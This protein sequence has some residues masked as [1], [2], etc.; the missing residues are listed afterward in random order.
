MHWLL[1]IGTEKTGSSHLQAVCS[2]ARSDLATNGIAF[3]PGWAHDERCMLAG[4]I[5][6]GNARQ[7]AIALREADD[8]LVHEELAAA[9]GY[10][11]RCNADRIV[12]T[13]EWLLA[14]LSSPGQTDRLLDAL[15][16]AGAQSVS[17]LI[18]LRDPLE[19]CLSLYKHRAKRGTAGAI[20]SWVT[21]GY[22][23]PVELNG[24]RQQV[25]ESGVELHVRCYR[26]TPGHLDQIFFK[27]WLD[28]PVPAV[29]VPKSVN[30]SLTLSE[31]VLVRQMAASYP[32]LV[33]PLFDAL[34]SI[35]PEEKVQGKV[36][37]AY[38]RAVAARAVAA[39]AEEWAAWQERL[40]AD[41]QLKIPLPP[42]AIPPRPD[43]L[44][45]SERQMQ[46]IAELLSEATT[47][48]FKARLL[49]RSRLR[50]A[51]GRLKRTVWR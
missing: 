14:A 11:Q 34:S 28:V 4:Q 17:F 18:V 39:H 3:P 43:E 5:S 15:K 49:W 35:D 40:P 47:L 8:R 16:E 44:G 23:L 50:P 30:P 1:H 2:R 37:D 27:E 38:A 13:S 24:F 21:S 51:L 29:A 36:L 20:E 25:E 42:D 6:A 10:A 12:L 26:R 7:L 41:E 33:T 32:P 22:Q 31:L 48:G 45:L 19:Q 46:A 9:A